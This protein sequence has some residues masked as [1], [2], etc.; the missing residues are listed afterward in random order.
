MIQPLQNM[1][2]KIQSEAFVQ[3]QAQLLSGFRQLQSASQ[4]NHRI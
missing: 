3:I 1:P 4:K 2:Q